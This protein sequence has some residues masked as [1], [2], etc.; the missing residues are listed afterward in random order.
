MPF[1]RKN[2]NSRQTTDL[3]IDL[4][5]GSDHSFNAGKRT[6]LIEVISCRII[7]ASI[8][9]QYKTNNSFFLKGGFQRSKAFWTAKCQNRI[10]IWKDDTISD[11]DNW[12]YSFL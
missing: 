12:N 5:V 4:S 7:Q 8:L 2:L 1:I 9:L 10:S 3:G 6:D 11:R